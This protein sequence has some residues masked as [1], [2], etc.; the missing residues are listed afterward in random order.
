MGDNGQL[1]ALRTDG[2]FKLDEVASA[3]QKEI[4]RGNAEDALFWALELFPKYSNYLWSRL[5]VISAEDI[6]APGACS[7]VNSLKEAFYWTNRKEKIV[8]D[9]RHRIFIS[10]AVLYLS[11]AKK[12]RESDHAQHYIDKLIKSNK[13]KQIPEYARDVHTKAGRLS[14]KTKKQFMQ[15]EQESLVNKGEDAFY[16]KL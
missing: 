9:Y 8:S 13:I 2:G 6:D 1:F 12:S 5:L 16:D 3:L 11:K 15:E 14:G 4:R 7:A 10:K